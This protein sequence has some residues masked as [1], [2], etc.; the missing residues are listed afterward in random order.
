MS[1]FTFLSHY[2]A[3]HAYMPCDRY[4]ML[5]I[6]CLGTLKNEGIGHYAKQVNKWQ[7]GVIFEPCDHVWLHLRGKIYRKATFKV[8]TDRR[9]IVS[10]DWESLQGHE[11]LL[12][13]F[14]ISLCR[15]WRS[16]DESFWRGEMME[17]RAH[18]K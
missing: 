13:M 8:T 12:L 9:W 15:A 4:I 14:L 16:R 10:N 1:N 3:Y 18:L 7:K 5:S 11:V 17:T 6:K 2:F